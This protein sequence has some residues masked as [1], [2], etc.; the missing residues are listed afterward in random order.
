[1]VDAK[2]AGFLHNVNKRR[3]WRRW[4]G[5]VTARVRTKVLVAVRVPFCAHWNR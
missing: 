5:A 4:C 1:V 2:F 3:Q